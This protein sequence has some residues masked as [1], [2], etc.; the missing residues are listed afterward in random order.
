MIIEPTLI[1]KVWPHVWPLI[2]ELAVLETEEDI[3]SELRVGFRLLVIV[4]DG[5]AIVRPCK[6]FFEINYVAGKNAKEW[7]PQ[8]SK[9]I[10]ALAISFGADKVVAFG[11]AAWKKLAPDF[12]PTETRMYVK[13]LEAA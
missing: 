5:V 1:D 11:R 2:Q 7:W 4:G 8:M 6:G 10:D 9:I 13:K 3:L 12:E